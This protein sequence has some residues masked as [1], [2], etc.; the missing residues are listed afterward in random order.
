[1][2]LL[3]TDPATVVHRESMSLTGHSAVILRRS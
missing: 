2:T 3:S 1:E